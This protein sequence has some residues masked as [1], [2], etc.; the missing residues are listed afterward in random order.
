MPECPTPWGVPIAIAECRHCGGAIGVDLRAHAPIALPAGPGHPAA[1]PSTCC[2]CPHCGRP[3]YPALSA[4]GPIALAPKPDATALIPKGGDP[5][6]AA[7]EP[8]A[9]PPV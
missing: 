2:A 7:T 8:I 1:M 4:V 6:L 3:L 5:R 9:R